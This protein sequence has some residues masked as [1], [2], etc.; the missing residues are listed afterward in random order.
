MLENCLTTFCEEYEFLLPIEAEEN[1]F[2]AEL[3]SIYLVP[4]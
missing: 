2:C 4:E 1:S 3:M